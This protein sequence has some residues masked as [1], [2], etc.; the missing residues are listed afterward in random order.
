MLTIYFSFAQLWATFPTKLMKRPTF[1]F[2]YFQSI[3]S[4]LHLYK[5]R[6]SKSFKKKN[7]G[8]FN[9]S[10]KALL[11]QQLWTIFSTNIMKN[12]S[13]LVTYCSSSFPFLHY[14]AVL[15][16]PHFYNKNDKGFNVAN[17]LLLISNRIFFTSCFSKFSFIYAL[18]FQ[19]FP[20]SA[21]HYNALLKLR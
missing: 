21:N 3:T 15:W 14:H 5:I 12:P 20:I 18:L 4:V 10:I 9:M 17:K 2:T 7:D 19:I 11:F 6:R 1:F 13:T 16:R 8:G